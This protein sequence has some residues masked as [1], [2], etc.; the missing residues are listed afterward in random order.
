MGR[1]ATALVISRFLER[2]AAAAVAAV[3][4]IIRLHGSTPLVRALLVRVTTVAMDRPHQAVLVAL[5]AVVGPVLLAV[6]EIHQMVATVG[7]GFRLPSQEPLFLMAAVEGALGALVLPV[8]VAL[9]A[10]ALGVLRMGLLVVRIL[11]AAVVARGRI[12]LVALAARVLSLF[13]RSSVV[14]RLV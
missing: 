9:V 11:A 4:A 7:L 1:L 3:L 12:T 13:A 10:V 2:K 8:L 6:L 14:Q 5:V